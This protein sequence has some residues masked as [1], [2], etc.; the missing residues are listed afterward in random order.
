MDEVGE[1][2]AYVDAEDGWLADSGLLGSLGWADYNLAMPFAHLE[3]HSNL[4]LL[5][6]TPSVDALAVRAAAEGMPSLALT[7]TNALYGAVA[8]AR[9]CEKAGVRPVIGMTVTL[10][11]PSLNGRAALASHDDP[12]Q[13]VL[14]AKNP[15]GYRSLCRLSTLVQ[16]SPE[17]EA[18]AARGLRWEDVAAHRAGTFDE[19]AAL[20]LEMD[21]PADAARASELAA[22]ARRLGL[23]LVAVRPIYTMTPDEAPRLRLLAA[24]RANR[25]LDR[26]EYEE[27]EE[28]EAREDASA[29]LWERA[30]VAANWPA[31][32]PGNVTRRGEP[33]PERETHWLSAQEM[34]ARYAG[35][36]RT[37]EAAGE[38]AAAC[39]PCLPD[40][41][42]IWPSLDLPQGQTPDD[43]LRALA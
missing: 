2:P 29:G 16:G 41:R 18:V 20:A 28:D 23:P 13:L 37:L 14:L 42:P 35:Y 25:P 12:G 40:G 8:F 11:L 31:A 33:S 34:A 7:D 24:I 27:G 19:S 38:V 26:I 17:R 21:G 4:T 32:T 9:A 30:P 3:V 15:A 6:A 10:Q 39:G 22:L 1:R 43:A 36:E 5:G